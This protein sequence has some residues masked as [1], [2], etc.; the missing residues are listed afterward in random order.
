MTLDKTDNK[1]N[2]SIFREKLIG[3]AIPID[4]LY[5]HG[6]KMEHNSMID[7]ADSMLL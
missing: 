2:F 6:N 7:R 3:A 4:S 5:P 1:I